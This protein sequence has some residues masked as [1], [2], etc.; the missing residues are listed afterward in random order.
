MGAFPVT[1]GSPRDA[2]DEKDWV[3]ISTQVL[4]GMLVMYIVLDGDVLGYAVHQKAYAATKPVRVG[5]ADHHDDC[6]K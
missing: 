5:P 3:A 6:P 1:A 4:D 2:V